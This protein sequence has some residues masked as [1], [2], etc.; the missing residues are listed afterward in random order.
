MP[1]QIGN[2][3]I[4]ADRHFP[5]HFTITDQKDRKPTTKELA[6]SKAP[7][8]VLKDVG[9]NDVALKNFISKILLIQ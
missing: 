6:G 8:L 7:D 2:K 5:A 3:Q 9:G 4:V 1:H